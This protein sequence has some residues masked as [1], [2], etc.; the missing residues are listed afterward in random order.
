[1]EQAAAQLIYTASPDFVAK[2]HV[3]GAM[4]EAMYKAS[5][6]DPD[7]FWAREGQRIDWIN[8]PTKIKNKDR[9]F[10]G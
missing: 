1:M 8:A 6:A 4:Y 9:R 7:A 3:D 5:V 2:A 10:L